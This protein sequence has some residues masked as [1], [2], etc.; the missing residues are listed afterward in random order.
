MKIEIKEG[1]QMPE[2]VTAEQVTDVVNKTL[3][4]PVTGPIH[5]F[6]LV[7]LPAR[8]DGSKSRLVAVDVNCPTQVVDGHR[9]VV[10]VS[11][12]EVYSGRLHDAWK[13]FAQPGVVVKAAEN[14]NGLKAVMAP[15]VRATGSVAIDESK[16]G[17]V[18]AVSVGRAAT[19]ITLNVSGALSSATADAGAE[20]AL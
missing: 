20:L 13:T 14:T 16:G 6:R 4:N 17:R 3:T 18:T 15:G 9:Y 10:A 5:S 2:G 12:A 7:E 19:F 8:E 11:I 1:V